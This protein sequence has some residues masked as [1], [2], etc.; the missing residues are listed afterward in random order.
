MLSWS[1]EEAARYLETYKAYEHKPAELLMERTDSDFT[2]QAIDCLTSVHKVNK[3]DAVTLLRTFKTMAA[4]LT[5][6]PEEMSLCP[7]IGLQKAQRLY[8]TFHEPFQSKK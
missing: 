8:D 6:L 7:G 2:S 4:I 3:T 5:A 1:P